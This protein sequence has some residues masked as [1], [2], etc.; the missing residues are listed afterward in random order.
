VEVPPATWIVRPSMPLAAG[1]YSCISGRTC[2]CQ[3]QLPHKGQGSAKPS[4]NGAG[5]KR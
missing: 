5:W 4:A 2:G 3:I 1:Q